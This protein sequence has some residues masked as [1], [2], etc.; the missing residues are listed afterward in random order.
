MATFAQLR[1]GV[2]AF[3]DAG[4]EML[5]MQYD[6]V[7]NYVKYK[8]ERE[9]NQD[10]ERSKSYFNSWN[11]HKVGL[12]GTLVTVSFAV[13][14]PEVLVRI[15]VDS[16]RTAIAAVVDKWIQE[17]MDD[18][19]AMKVIF[20]ALL[21]AGCV[22]LQRKVM[23]YQI[24]NY[25][26]YTNAQV[27]NVGMASFIDLSVL[28][29]P[30]LLSVEIGR[31]YP[32]LAAQAYL[33]NDKVISNGRIYHCVVPGTVSVVGGGLLSMDGK[34]EVLGTATFKFLN[35]VGWTPIG[36]LNWLNNPELTERKVPGHSHCYTVDPTGR[37]MYVYPALKPTDTDLQVRVQY[38]GLKQDFLDADDV[39]FD[40]PTHE[41]LAHYIRGNIEQTLNADSRNASQH[42]ALYARGVRMLWV[43]CTR[44]RSTVLGRVSPP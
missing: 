9:V 29:N 8:I 3:Y 36:A 6:A 32:A 18:L 37:K 22:D 43:D 34:D 5:K 24:G 14:K 12:A 39:T 38:N 19:D 42:L 11:E 30:E 25:S 2:Q 4:A 26:Y 31:F 27:T 1:L 44:R 28:S 16:Q 15:T 21:K 20:D 7:A 33:A 10:L 40:F 35:T 23:C 17:A 41:P 13:M